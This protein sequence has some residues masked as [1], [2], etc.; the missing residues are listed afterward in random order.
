[1]KDLAYFEDTDN[2]FLLA[3][4]KSSE[5]FVRYL[6]ASDEWEDCPIS[7]SQFRHDHCFREMDRE[8][9]FRRTSGNLP[10]TLFERYVALLGKK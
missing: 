1:M 3:Y 7:F 9:A 10:E 5:F 8:E 6:S 4:E 2:G